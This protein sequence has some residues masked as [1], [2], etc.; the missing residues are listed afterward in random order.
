MMLIIFMKSFVRL[1]CSVDQQHMTGL[2]CCNFMQKK[3]NQITYKFVLQLTPKSNLQ[4]LNIYMPL[5][6]KL[7]L[8]QIKA[9]DNVVECV[10][11]NI[12]LYVSD[13]IEEICVSGQTEA[14]EQRNE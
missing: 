12:H 6:L 1:I 2:C 5:L 4:M 8:Y 13:N 14:E 11:Q 7:D 9:N 3:N 10:S